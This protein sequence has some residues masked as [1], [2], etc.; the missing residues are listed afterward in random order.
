MTAG[1]HP[2]QH[3]DRAQQRQQRAI[4]RRRDAVALTGRDDGTGQT[5]E[6]ERPPSQ[7]IEIHRG[8]DLGRVGEKRCHRAHRFVV[9]Q[10]GSVGREQPRSP[11]R[12]REA[13][14][15]HVVTA[16]H[17]LPLQRKRGDRIGHGI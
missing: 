10:L 5:L 17:R 11:R 6:L 13:E 1:A 16:K 12:G 3:A 7:A 15:V 9:G 2:P 8:T 14:L 4:E